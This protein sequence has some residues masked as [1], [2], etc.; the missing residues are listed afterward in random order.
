MKKRLM[1]LLLIS[2]LSLLFVT[3][4]NGDA[5]TPNHMLSLHFESFWD[6]AANQIPTAAMLLGIG[7]V[8]FAGIQR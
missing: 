2:G 7:I 4:S 8:G 3:L 1:T 6:Y 5:A